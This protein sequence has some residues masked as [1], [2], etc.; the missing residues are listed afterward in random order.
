M[1]G[2]KKEFSYYLWDEYM[3]FLVFWK[4][5]GLL[6]NTGLQKDGRENEDRSLD[7]SL[8]QF[9]E[10]IWRWQ[11]EGWETVVRAHQI[12]N[13]PGKKMDVMLVQMQ[14]IRCWLYSA[15]LQK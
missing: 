9:Q 10:D 7:F 12:L 5:E 8:T 2:C 4:K 11:G 6:K 13:L 1:P 14:I 15:Q 3:K